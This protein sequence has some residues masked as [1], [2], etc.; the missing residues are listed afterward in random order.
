[1]YAEGFRDL[2]VYP[3]LKSL[4]L[5]VFQL[6]K[7]FPSEEKYSLTSQLRRASRSA[8]AQISE[9]WAKRRY[10]AHFISKLTDADGEQRET[11]H[12]IDAALDC[13]Y[14]DR[15]VRDELIAGYEE[16]GRMIQG[17]IDKAESFC[18]REPQ[19]EY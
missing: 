4:A 8:A 19:A 9:A 6:S 5:R 2:K 18:F 10:K 15:S 11:Q 1:M 7:R 14:I 3:T 16:F 17:M 12:W 13:G